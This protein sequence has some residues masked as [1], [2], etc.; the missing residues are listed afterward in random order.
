MMQA[1]SGGTLAAMTLAAL[2]SLLAACN[3]GSE[4]DAS[5]SASSS[6]V[7]RKSSVSASQ[8]PQPVFVKAVASGSA[9]QNI[10]V[11]FELAARPEVG[12]STDLKLV[13][14]GL[15]D[16]N[17]VRLTVKAGSPVKILTGGQANFPSLK[18]GEEHEHSVSLHGDATGIALVDV[19][20]EAT[21]DGG[22]RTLNYT[23]PIAVVESRPEPTPPVA[24]AS[25]KAPGAK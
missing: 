25:S 13:L 20:L 3:R 23:V 4:P 11:H 5:A 18:V 1:T 21:I 9:A 16:A 8:P 2:F 6:S 19:Q 22:P 10:D 12:K 24:A 14:L 15:A 7:S 17:N